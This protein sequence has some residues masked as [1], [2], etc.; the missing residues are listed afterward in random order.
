VLG[1][2]VGT[3]EENDGVTG[4]VCDYIGSAAGHISIRFLT[5][6]DTAGFATV[7]AGFDSGALSTRD[8]AGLGDEA[9]SFTTAGQF[10]NALGVRQGSTVIIVYSGASLD[11][12]KTLIQ[13]LLTTR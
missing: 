10:T 13:T 4:T 11:A 6:E 2:D 12:E 1:T 5:H 8:F 7:R 9:F 3:P